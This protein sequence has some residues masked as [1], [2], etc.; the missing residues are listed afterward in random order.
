M[1]RTLQD[2]SDGLTC[3]PR[4]SQRGNKEVSAGPFEIVHVQE[5]SA[6]KLPCP[7]V[8]SFQRIP[9]R[10][11]ALSPFRTSFRY[12]RPPS[13]RGDSEL[14]RDGLGSAVARSLAASPTLRE[15]QTS[16]AS[17]RACF[18]THPVYYLHLKQQILAMRDQ[19]S[20]QVHSLTTE[21]LTLDS[22]PAASVLLSLCRLR[23]RLSSVT[24]SWVGRDFP[25][26]YFQAVVPCRKKLNMRA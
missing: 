6:L 25:A 19:W 13:L 20:F 2:A 1:L 3:S 4:C 5:N 23:F 9:A 16:T 21:Y 22:S 26:F 10:F 11:G 12:K 17:L 15:K 14:Q 24:M 7:V 18:I 8:R